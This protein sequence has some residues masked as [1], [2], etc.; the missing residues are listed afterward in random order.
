LAS[1]HGEA[2][3]LIRSQDDLGRIDLDLAAALANP[4]GT[5]DVVLQPGDSLHIP[6]YSATVVV[7]GAV[8]SPVT[9]LWRE[10]QDFHHYIEA[11][12]GF[13]YDADEGRTSVQLASGLARS[14]SKFLFWSSY[15]TPDAG[16]TINVPVKDPTDQ[17]NKVQ[18]TSNLV[19]ILGS[20]ATLAI[21]IDRN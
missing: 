11:A 14:R 4:D 13:R 10:G 16:S 7:Q 12:G 18:F 17:F 6:E 20:L 9:V 15:P 2:A 3:R 5:N 21:V 8:N 19:A 1:G